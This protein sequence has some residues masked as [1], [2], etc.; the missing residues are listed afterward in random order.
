MLPRWYVFVWLYF[1]Q[2]PLHPPPPFSHPHTLIF[3]RSTGFV[4]CTGWGQ[5]G[6]ECLTRMYRTRVPTFISMCHAAR[7]A[8]QLNNVACSCSP[9]LSAKA[10]S[11]ARRMRCVSGPM[12]VAVVMD[13]L[14]L[15]VTPVRDFLFLYMYYQHFQPH[16][17]PTLSFKGQM[18]RNCFTCEYK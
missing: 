10:T 5:L 14:E 1:S 4:C 9:K 18:N 3:S 6:D 17:L 7:C 11:P 16:C 12:N 13:T 8:S 15:A 2:I